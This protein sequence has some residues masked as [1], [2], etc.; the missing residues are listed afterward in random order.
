MTIIAGRNRLACAKELGWE[1]IECQLLTCSDISASLIEIDE[2]LI[3]KQLTVL[4][5]GELSIR[6]RELLLQL[7]EV[8]KRGGD[9]KS[10]KAKSSPKTSFTA[11]IAEKQGKS[12]RTVEE[13]IQIVKN[14]DPTVRDL[15][16]AT[17]FANRKT[18]LLKLCK[19]D[20][21]NQLKIAQHIANGKSD[22]F[23]EAS[24]TLKPTIPDVSI[25]IMYEK[26]QQFYKSL[27]QLSDLESLL[28]DLITK[29]P[30][31][32]NRIKKEARTISDQCR[33]AIDRLSKIQSKLKV[34]S[35][36]TIKISKYKKSNQEENE[37]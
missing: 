5:A 17:A 15:I 20:S 31:N 10:S 4:E 36:Q 19:L 7:N 12:K 3:R 35:K 23:S 32:K 22:S 2:N 14:L 1:E 25:P 33:H 26:L 28:D 29:L 27:P 9:R 6:R 11:D 34:I 30:H 16:R 24:K 18:D 37:S 8:N 21:K 13:E